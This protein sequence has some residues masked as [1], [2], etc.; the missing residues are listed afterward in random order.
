MSRVWRIQLANLSLQIGFRHLDTTDWVASLHALENAASTDTLQAKRQRLKYALAAD[1]SS[2][3]GSSIAPDCTVFVGGLPVSRQSDLTEDVGLQIDTASYQD[4]QLSFTRDRF[5]SINGSIARE[6]DALVK[7]RRKFTFGEEE[8]DLEDSMNHISSFASLADLLTTPSSSRRPSRV[9]TIRSSAVPGVLQEATNQ[10]INGAIDSI[11]NES[12]TGEENQGRFL[13]RVSS[14]LMNRN[15]DFQHVDLWVPT[16]SEDDS[17]SGGRTRLTNAGSATIKN[18]ALSSQVLGRLNE[19]GVYSKN[20]SFAPGFG[21]PGR[22]F[23]TRQPSW[24]SCLHQ[25]G[26]RMYGIQTALGLPIPSRIGTMVVALY[27][28]SALVRDQEVEAECMDYFRK[29]QPVPRWRLSIEVAGDDPQEDAARPLLGR[30]TNQVGTSS[31]C[32]IP[33]SPVSSVLER[34]PSNDAACQ[35]NEQSLALLLG[36]YDS[37]ENQSQAPTN[38][39]PA[40][41]L[42]SLRLLLLRH[43]SC[44]TT[45]QSNQLFTIMSKYQ[46]Y[47]DLGCRETEIVQ[48]IAKD[49][50]NSACANPT[51]VTNTTD[52][53]SLESVCY[54][55]DGPNPYLF[56][57]A[58]AFSPALQYDEKSN[59][60]RVVSEAAFKSPD[61]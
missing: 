39:G 23:S 51:S 49:L 16:E 8:L 46:T 59:A 28:T 58:K 61:I 52:F 6:S 42:M 11:V 32:I 3:Y 5:D 45:V 21:M 2:S 33:T 37:P 31:V 30:A 43:P 55:E 17:G 1:A 47:V 25:A 57:S 29:L 48:F 4:N 12:F 7:P 50:E 19:F 60:P 18:S 15:Y 40:E 38:E 34:E 36:K 27:S 13:Q 22:V 14:F 10:V 44:R 26:A 9:E 24:D 53:P 20:F 35:L 56:S 54:Q 41:S